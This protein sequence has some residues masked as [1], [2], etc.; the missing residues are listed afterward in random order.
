MNNQLYVVWFSYSGTDPI[1]C[2]GFNLRTSCIVC[3]APS[4]L[5]VMACI[6]RNHPGS[7]TSVIPHI[8]AVHLTGFVDDE[9]PAVARAKK[10]AMLCPRSVVILSVFA[11]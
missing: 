1:M 4:I 11:E 8:S 9:P 10:H 2:S 6:E 3:Y 7:V 5:S